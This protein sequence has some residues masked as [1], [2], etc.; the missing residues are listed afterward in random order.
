MPEHVQRVGWWDGGAEAGDPFGAV[1][2][3]GHV[4]SATEGIGFFVRLRQVKAGEIVVLNGDGGHSAEY[5]IDSVVSVP[6]NAL[7]TESGAFDQTGDHRLVL[8]TCTGAYDRVQRW[9]RKNL[10]VTADAGGAGE[11]GVGYHPVGGLLPGGRGRSGKSWRHGLKDIAGSCRSRRWPLVSSPPR[12]R[13]PLAASCRDQSLDGVW[14]MD[15]YGTI[16]AIDNG[17][18][19]LYSTTQHQL[20]AGRRTAERQPVHRRRASRP[21]RSGRRDRAACTSKATSAT[22]TFAGCRAPEDLHGAWGDWAA[23]C[24]RPVLDD[25]AENYPFF[26]AKGIDWNAVRAKYRPR[27]TPGMSDDALFGLADRR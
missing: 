14:Q 2:L 15:G 5:R 22:S 27:V 1:V 11:V 19:Q 13:R 25:Y 16:V 20:Y 18:A 17:K 26:K 24:L 8:I 23:G 10:V 3:A 7:A 6:K 21:S 9:L 4:D 12:S